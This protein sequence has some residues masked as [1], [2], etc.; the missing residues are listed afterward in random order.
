[1]NRAGFYIHIPFCRQA[2]RY[3]D[4]HFSVSLQYINEMVSAM[5]KEMEMRKGIYRTLEFSTLYFGGGTPSVL[6]LEILHELIDH[7]FKRYEFSVDP[8]I[9]LEANPDDLTKDYL[10]GLKQMGFNRLSIGIQSFNESDLVL[11]RRSHTVEQAIYAIKNA[12]DAGFSNIN[13]DLIYGI[14]GLKLANWE[15][16]LNQAMD[17]N[18]QHISAY[19]LT[20]EPGTVFDLWKKKKR[21]IPVE[22]EL[23]LAQF[24]ILKEVTGRNRFIHYEISNFAKDGFYSKHNSLYWNQVPYIGIG[25][26][27]H[28]F[29]KNERRWNISHN[30]KYIE[31]LLHTDDKYY[32][33]EELSKKDRYNEFVLTSL[34]THKGI[35]LYR[36]GERFGDNYVKYTLDLANC[37]L[38]KGDLIR[39]KN[40]IF[41]SEKG[42][43]I[44][45][46]IMRELFILES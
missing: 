18:I 46:F 35:D 13:I 37:F 43:M 24:K 42:I 44:S 12:Q 2:C 29:L 10:K 14:P 9:T 45:D 33:T 15:N 41:L 8:E 30:K 16:N 32:D 22:D 25:P 20:F 36:L 5:K 27:A 28:S 38:E 34:R 40:N 4:F 19:H 21:I 6:D 26:S 3:C 31:Y 23:S 1:M 17:L 39:T 7:A 11:M